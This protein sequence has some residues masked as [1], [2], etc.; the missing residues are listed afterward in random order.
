METQPRFP[1]VAMAALLGVLADISGMAALMLSDAPLV[2]K[3]L[4]GACNLIVLNTLIVWYAAHRH[5][6]KRGRRD[7]SGE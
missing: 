2:L 4:V 1:W 6:W 3:I 7:D 5:A